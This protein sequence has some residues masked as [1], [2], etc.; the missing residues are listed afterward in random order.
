MGRSPRPRAQPT[1]GLGPN[2]QP[3]TQPSAHDGAPLGAHRSPFLHKIEALAF[4]KL[5]NHQNKLLFIF[6]VLV[7]TLTNKISLSNLD[8]IQVNIYMI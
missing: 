6:A 2:H 1:V 5:L 4:I 8:E 7:L 3:R